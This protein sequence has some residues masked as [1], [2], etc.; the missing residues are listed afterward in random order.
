[1]A[2]IVVSSLAF[3]HWHHKAFSIWRQCIDENDIFQQ[4]WLNVM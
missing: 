4:R 3:H 1:M 2:A